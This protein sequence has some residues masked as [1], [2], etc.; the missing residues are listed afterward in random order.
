MGSSVAGS[1]H[2]SKNSWGARGKR[3]VPH[4][5][6][7]ESGWTRHA[8]QGVQQATR[9]TRH[10][11]PCAPRHD[12]FHLQ[13]RATQREQTTKT[14]AQMWVSCDNPYGGSEQSKGRAQQC[15]NGVRRRRRMQ[16]RIAKKKDRKKKRKK[17]NHAKKEN[18]DTKWLHTLCSGSENGCQVGKTL[19]VCLLGKVGVPGR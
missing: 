6:G 3:R 1:P 16:R 7:N 17:K 15:T 14:G 13:V 8:R 9:V 12:R 2:S 19:N 4:M 10:D 11:S 18:A 5:H